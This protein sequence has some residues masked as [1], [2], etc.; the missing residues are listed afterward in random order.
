MMLEKARLD[1]L[2][3][4]SNLS[5][6]LLVTFYAV[7]IAFPINSTRGTTSTSTPK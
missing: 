5:L 1:F 6:N 4:I 2:P 7:F 3:N